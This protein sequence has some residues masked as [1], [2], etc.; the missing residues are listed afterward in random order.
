MAQNYYCKDGKYHQKSEI[1]ATL[2]PFVDYH[3]SSGDTTGS[4][5][6]SFQ[7]KYKNYLTKILPE[8]AVIHKWNKNHYEFSAVIERN[9]KFAYVRIDDVR[10]WPNAWFT[11]ILVR[12]MA[13]DT[14][15]HGG[16][17]HDASL[18]NLTEELNKL[19]A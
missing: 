11:N 7:R 16:P 3:F 8:G 9:G 13:H 17:N 5:Y 14:D 6:L 15:W 19:L 10:Y 1:P 12:T 4:D 18:F 2:R